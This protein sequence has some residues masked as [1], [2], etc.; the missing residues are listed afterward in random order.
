MINLQK[1][2]DVLIISLENENKLNAAMAQ[3]FKVEVSKLIDQPGIKMAI[4]LA[5]VNYIDSSGF[6]AL[7]SILRAAKNNDSQVKL[8]NITPQVM[9]LVTLLQ[10]QTVFDIRGSLDECLKAF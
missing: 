5:D 1:I 10:L 2:D 3:Q 4:N 8:C 9:E 7:L 6:G